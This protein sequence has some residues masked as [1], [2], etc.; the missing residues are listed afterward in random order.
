MIGLIIVGHGEFGR[1]INS[2]IELV[3]GKQEL[4]EVVSFL[5]SHST[6]DLK[7]NIEEAIKTMGAEKTLILTDLP[8]GSPFKA[9]VE[10]S[11]TYENIEVIAGTN[12]PMIMEILF[13]RNDKDLVEVRNKA[14]SAGKQQIVTFEIPEEV[15]IEIEEDGI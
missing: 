4:L 7:T 10:L 15:A 1:G 3:A 14:I 11:M 9:A 12:L 13:D 6:E 2:A 8:G 5:Q